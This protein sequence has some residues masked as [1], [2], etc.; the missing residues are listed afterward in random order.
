MGLW[1]PQ[2]K[3]AT[4]PM[5]SCLLCGIVDVMKRLLKKTI[6]LFSVKRSAMT[7]GLLLMPGLVVSSALTPKQNEINATP[8]ITE[9][10]S[11]YHYSQPRLDNALSSSTLDRYIKLLDPSK[12]F[13]TALDIA[14]FEPYRY[15]L[16]EDFKK[17]NLTAA[18]E[19]FDRYTQQV[20]KQI[21]YALDVLEQPHDFTQEESY[22]IDYENEPWA[23]DNKALHEV[24]RKRVKNDI[25]SLKIAGKTTAE[26]TQTL[27]KRYQNLLRQ[28]KRQKASDI[29][30]IFINAYT[31]SIDPHT[32]YFSAHHSENFNI[33]MRLSLEGIGAAL[34]SKNEYTIVQKIIPGGPA[35]LSKQL[36]P[37]DRII[38]VAQGQKAMQDVIGWRLQE[39]V[40]KI[41]G[42][43]N[44]VV[45]L[46][47]LPRNAVL[48]SASKEITLVRDQI[49]LEEQAAKSSI[50][51]IT[52]GGKTTK[53]GIIEIPTFYLDFEARNRGD[54]DYKSTTR[55]VRQLIV[56]LKSQN[57]DGLLMDLRNN[58][59]GSLNE[60][61]ELTGLF[62]RRGPVVQVRNTSGE[63]D[64]NN[65]PDPA[66]VYEG[67]LAV[68]VNQNSASAS[69]IFAG[70]I[71]D[72]NR[73][74][75][76]GEPTFGKGTVQTLIDLNRFSR[77]QQD[78]G[79]LKIT[80]AKFFRINGDSTQHR[81][82][83]PDIIYPT[84]INSTDQGERS[85]DNALPWTKVDA[86]NYQKF[87]NNDHL[88]DIEPL[89]QRHQQR[90]A[91]DH[92]FR[93]LLSLSNEVKRAQDK[94]S[95]SLVERI[96]RKEHDHLQQR[97][98]TLENEFR[99][100]RGLD[101]L[102]LT[103]KQAEQENEDRF[104][105]DPQDDPITTIEVNE[106]AHILSDF[107]LSQQGQLAK[108][109]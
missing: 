52:N 53:I 24:W 13:F 67:P 51:E 17:A 12:H 11:N 40:E 92:G 68:L 69:E 58:G 62:I 21:T 97:T 85:L 57:I 63:I 95:V 47:L 91:K 27:K 80:V 1:H 56:K 32:T 70:A 87:I 46:L 54:S 90:I 55:D 30:Q 28:T 104:D 2:Y 61:T 108:L 50:T 38:G 100:S 83:Q 5:T 26:L 75:V 98:L 84:A 105:D 101:L 39:V 74:L 65:D 31:N 60:A 3:A 59:G 72:Y 37:G 78:L 8:L 4:L 76:I 106:A 43:R 81:G 64:I 107:I 23:R 10:V 9:L 93:Y 15:Q 49:K 77:N 96:R 73:G 45:R 29:F 88:I 79:Q 48:E 7:I 71:Q 66:L 44:S 99:R 102:T 34:R 33:N 20:V 16:D 86:V 19:I 6:R 89:R 109:R 22:I 42:P 25:L 35:D 103:D 36:K 82:V 41:R 14:H 18:F 94:R